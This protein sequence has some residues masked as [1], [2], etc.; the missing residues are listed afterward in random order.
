MCFTLSGQNEGAVLRSCMSGGRTARLAE[1]A[2]CREWTPSEFWAPA[3]AAGAMVNKR[4]RYRITVLGK[5][6][7]GALR[8]MVTYLL[9]SAQTDPLNR[10]V[11]VFA[12]KSHGLGIMEEKN[13]LREIVKKAMK[14]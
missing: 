2:P 4:Y 8:N 10:G 6:R 9:E 5:E 3:A 13:M 7:P 11:S 14:S 12:D 1:G